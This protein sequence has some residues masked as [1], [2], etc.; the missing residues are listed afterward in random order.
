MH[1][2]VSQWKLVSGWGQGNG[3]SSPPYGPCG[4][5]RTWRFTQVRLQ[6]SPGPRSAPLWRRQT[7][8]QRTYSFITD[9]AY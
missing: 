5:G 4:W 2:V 1:Y 6:F 7:R 9:C 3:R 8:L